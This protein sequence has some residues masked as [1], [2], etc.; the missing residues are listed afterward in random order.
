[1]IEAMDEQL[2]ELFDAIRDDPKLRDNTLVVF[3]SDNGPEPGAGSGGPFR[4]AKGTLFEAGIRSPLIVSGP[5]V[6]EK[7]AVGT[8][9]RGSVFSTLDL[10]ATLRAIAGA[11]ASVGEIDGEVLTNTLIGGASA[12][13]VAPLFFR[14]PP[15]RKSWGNYK[16][17]PD[18]AV[19]D[20]RWKLLCNYDGSAAILYD[21]DADPGETTDVSARQPEL[22]ARLSAA[23]SAWHQ[24]LP[25]DR[26][27]TYRAASGKK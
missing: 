23:A 24:S 21:L 10:N 4:G 20:G 22:T 25:P 27:A 26:G 5:G 11:A 6:L 8:V 3:C 9:D 16:D 18:L 17:L 2:G 14:R 7:S 19:R 15:D 12:S 13:R 1:V